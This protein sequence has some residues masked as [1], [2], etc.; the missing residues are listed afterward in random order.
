MLI[1]DSLRLAPIFLSNLFIKSKIVMSFKIKE[2]HFNLEKFHY[3]F[4]PVRVFQ[5]K[6]PHLKAIMGFKITL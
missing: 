2:I 3:I 4:S 1:F 5:F 6:N